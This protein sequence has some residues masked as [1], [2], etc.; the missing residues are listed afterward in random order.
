MTKLEKSL[1]AGKWVVSTPYRHLILATTVLLVGAA[2]G[3]PQTPAGLVK[4]FV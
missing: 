1:G 3:Q 4:F 2:C